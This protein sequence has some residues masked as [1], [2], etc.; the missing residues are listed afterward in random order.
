[1]RFSGAPCVATMLHAHEDRVWCVMTIPDAVLTAVLRTLV[2][3]TVDAHQPVVLRSRHHA[4]AQA[5]AGWLAQAHGSGRRV[6]A[7]TTARAPVEV[8]LPAQMNWARCTATAATLALHGVGDQLS[9]MIHHLP[10]CG[11]R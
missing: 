2:R 3:A 6:F 4:Q 9:V 8:R 1:M 5:L 10:D 11:T 7:S